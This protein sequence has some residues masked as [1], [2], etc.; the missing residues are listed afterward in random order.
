ML[1]K[2]FTPFCLKI[3]AF[4]TFLVGVNAAA[5]ATHIRAGEIIAERESCQGFTYLITVVGYVDTG[6][7][8]DF[9][10]GILDFGFGE[11]IELNTADAFSQD[12]II[13]PDQQIARSTYKVRV[14]F[15]DALTVYDYL[16]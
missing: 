12:V 14:E 4:L 11:P 6:S 9:G 13:S 1:Y 3:A 16:P 15:P 2:D 10:N 8:V 5:Y 7:D